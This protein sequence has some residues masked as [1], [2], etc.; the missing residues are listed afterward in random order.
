MPTWP[1]LRYFACIIISLRFRLFFCILRTECLPA[2]EALKLSQDVESCLPRLRIARKVSPQPFQCGSTKMLMYTFQNLLRKK[3]KVFRRTHRP[4][5]V[6]FY[7]PA[8]PQRV[9]LLHKSTDPQLLFST[10]AYQSASNSSSESPVN[11]TI[12]ATDAPRCFNL[13]AMATIVSSRPS[14]RP[15]S[16]PS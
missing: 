15:I 7:C 9:R 5:E 14:S 16:R 13:R 11:S 12:S 8:K 2:A 10:K 4:T 1:G 6:G 3:V